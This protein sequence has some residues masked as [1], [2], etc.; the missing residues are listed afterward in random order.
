VRSEK[1]AV[2]GQVAGGV[3]HELRNPLGVISNAVYFLQMVLSDADET[4]QE[5]LGIISSEIRNAG[6]IVS[7][8]LDFSRTRPAEREGVGVSRLVAKVLEKQP[9]SE[10]MEVTIEI[11]PDLPAVFVD[12]QQIGQVLANLVTNAFQAMPDGGELTISAR[13]DEDEVQLSVTD[14]GCGISQENRKLIFEPLFTTRARGIGLGL[15]ISKNLV[16]ANGGTI[17]VQSE[18][19]RGSTFTVAL[20]MHGGGKHSNEGVN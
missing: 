3:G 18:E 13:A 11:T 12:P 1:L 15:A 14:T 16:E 10:N 17:K 4:T 6:K 2:L 8:L 7:D 9:P 20:A 19:G 5:Y